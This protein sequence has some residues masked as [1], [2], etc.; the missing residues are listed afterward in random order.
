LIEK[1]QKLLI[2]NLD[3]KFL[4]NPTVQKVLR[5]DMVVSQR[6]QQ[7]PCHVNIFSDVQE[8]EVQYHIL[9]SL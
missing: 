3:A 6:Q 4:I 2:V 9:A 5:F 7:H 8:N 1:K